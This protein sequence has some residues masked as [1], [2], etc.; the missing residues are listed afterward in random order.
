MSYPYM[1]VPFATSGSPAN[2][3]QGFLDLWTKDPP[4]RRARDETLAEHH[5]RAS[6]AYAVHVAKIDTHYNRELI[7]TLIASLTVALETNTPSA[8]N[9]VENNLLQ[10]FGFD[11]LIACVQDQCDQLQWRFAQLVEKVQSVLA[12]HPQ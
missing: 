3:W 5:A 1:F 8:F 11:N 9:E 4:N 7:Q 6:R 2:V 10:F 12:E